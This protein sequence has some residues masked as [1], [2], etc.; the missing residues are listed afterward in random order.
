MLDKC[1]VGGHLTLNETARRAESRTKIDKGGAQCMQCSAGV[2]AGEQA[3]VPRI[4]RIRINP[5]L[6]RN[7]LQKII[8]FE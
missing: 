3:A 1:S 8:Y 6:I 2:R 7:K 5:L 4:N